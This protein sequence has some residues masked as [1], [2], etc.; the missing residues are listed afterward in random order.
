MWCGWFT[1]SM[2]LGVPPT[3]SSPGWLCEFSLCSLCES[4]YERCCHCCRWTGFP[5]FV[6][7]DTIELCQRSPAF[8]SEWA[9]EYFDTLRVPYERLPCHL[10]RDLQRFCDSEGTQ[11]DCAREVLDGCFKKLV[12]HALCEDEPEEL[13]LP[14]RLQCA[15]QRGDHHVGS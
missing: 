9:E 6:T 4:L 3:S 12:R 7:P 15:V 10:Q 11:F 2:C 1:T 14:P 13:Q 8:L 5:T